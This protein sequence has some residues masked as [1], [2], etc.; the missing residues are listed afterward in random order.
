M[1][2]KSLTDL[3]VACHSWTTVSFFAH[4]VSSDRQSDKSRMTEVE[5]AYGD[6]FIWVYFPMS[7]GERV[8]GFWVLTRLGGHAT[9]VVW[10]FF[11]LSIV[12]QLTIF[13]S[14]HHMGDLA[15]LDLTMNL[16]ITPISRFNN[17]MAARMVISTPFL[18]RSPIERHRPR[19]PLGC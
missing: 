12:T 15:Y 7:P 10:N 6:A 13:R 11:L 3:T 16:R 9:V 19:S 5:R 17:S 8:F 2:L 1:S 18:Q 4:H 14:T